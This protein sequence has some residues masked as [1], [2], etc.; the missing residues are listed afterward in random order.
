M[1]NCSLQDAIQNNKAL[2]RHLVRQT[3]KCINT[4]DILAG[5]VG[6]GLR[7]AP[8]VVLPVTGSTD[9]LELP[10]ELL[11]QFLS[12]LPACVEYDKESKELR[13]WKKEYESGA[14]LESQR[15]YPVL[16]WWWKGGSYPTATTVEW[17]TSE[18][19]CLTVIPEGI[20]SHNSRQLAE[21]AEFVKARWK[22]NAQSKTQSPDTSEGSS[23]AEGK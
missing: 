11:E 15:L 9:R 22:P 5:F 19:L 13:G 14:N 1:K 3:P 21:A 17:A 2:Q 16:G 18:T 8:V 6:G 4:G 12:R 7:P 10:P 20:S 23:S